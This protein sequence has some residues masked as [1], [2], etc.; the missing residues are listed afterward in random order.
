MTLDSLFAKARRARM[1]GAVTGLIAAALGVTFFSGCSSVGVGGPAHPMVQNKPALLPAQIVA[2]FFLVEARQVDG[3]T[4]RF[5][6]DTGSSATLVSPGLAAAL[7]QKKKGAPPRTV[8]IRGADGKE[9]GLEEV[10]L[11]QL[12]LGDAG[13]ERVPAVIYDFTDLSDHLGVR[14]DGVIGFPLFREKLLTLDYPAARLGIAPYPLLAPPAPKAAPRATTLT[15]NN[16][17]TTPLIPVQ[18]GNESF[19]VLIDSGNDGGLSL[20]P[21]GLHPQFANGPRPGK[22][23]ASL[24]GDHPQ[25][26]GRL[27]QDVLVGTH[28]IAQPVVDLTDQLSSL[29]GELLRHFSLAFDQRRNRVTLVRDT[30]TAVE[31][32]PRHDTG[33]SFRRYPAY[34]RVLAVVPDTPAAQ[35][36]VQSG[37]L[38]V[39]V[40]GE[41]V[42]LWDIERYAALLRTATKVTYTFIVGPKEQDIEMPVFNLVP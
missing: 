33:L 10:T 3:K 18:M 11:R 29:G 24:A 39:R 22:L 35:S 9:V 14:I 2:N 5:M 37:D 41:P 38:C 6:I 34:W 40:N 19:F 8:P 36:S 32:A 7:R 13:F 16:E 27:A 26:V 30:D 15:F 1:G 42:A 28:T 31:M 20:N 23:A 12:L 21:T 4:Y 17:Q 25:L